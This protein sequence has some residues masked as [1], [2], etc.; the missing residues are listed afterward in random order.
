[1]GYRKIPN[2]YKDQRILQ[3]KE[4]YALEK[5]HGTSAHISWSINTQS[6]IL[7][8]GGME[9]LTFQKCFN[10]DHLNEAFRR[11]YPN[12]N[13]VIYGEAYGGRMHGNSWR[14]GKLAQFVGFEV[15]LD[16]HI[17]SV[18]QASM[19]CHDLDID[20][21]PY[22]Q[23]QFTI[24]NIDSER[25]RPSTQAEKIAKYDNTVTLPQPREGVVLR[26]L[27][28]SF[29]ERGCLIIA[30]HK[31]IE[32]RE[33]KTPRDITDLDKLQ[34][35]KEAG[36]IAEEWVT[37]ERLIHVL[38]AFPNT[39]INQTSDVVKAMISDIE[40]EAKGEIVES[41]SARKAIGKLTAKLF[42]EYLKVSNDEYLAMINATTT[43]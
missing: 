13:V 7:F 15:Q 24:E 16:K 11:F 14:Y 25:D 17:Q 22:T 27:V 21:V 6:M 41:R 31:R 23:I 3:F 38:D 18:P 1:M 29:D 26:P 34:I 33:T 2:L 39:Q 40:T 5:I 37:K 9:Y 10:Q 12:T 20:F 30:K 28:E 4:G 8:S 19:I 43:H 36:A 35:L 42:K 32:E